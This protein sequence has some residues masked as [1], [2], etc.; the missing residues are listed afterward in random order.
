MQF[1]GYDVHHKTLGVI[2]WVESAKG[3]PGEPRVS[4]CA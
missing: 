1:T 4:T 2:G 3:S